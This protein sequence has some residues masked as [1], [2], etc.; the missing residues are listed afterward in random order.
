MLD[1]SYQDLQFFTR[2]RCMGECRTGVLFRAEKTAD[3]MT[4]VYVALNTG[5]LSAFR[6]TLNAAGRE[7]AR[8]PLRVVSPFIR[9]APVPGAPARGAPRR[10]GAG[11]GGA[12]MTL[13]VPL[14]PLMPPRRACGRTS[15]TCSASRSTPTSFGP[16]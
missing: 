6:L 13:P 16:R 5:E 11:T 14:A 4:G 3:G 10:G 8:E 12:V 1:A 7:T 9:S 15:G 2:F